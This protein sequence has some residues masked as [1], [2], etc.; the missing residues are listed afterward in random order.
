MPVGFGA[1]EGFLFPGVPDVLQPSQ[2]LDGGQT[3][4]LG[5]ATSQRAQDTAD[6]AD[7]YWAVFPISFVA[8]PEDPRAGVPA[9]GRMPKKKSA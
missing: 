6:E 4:G 3:A 9:L 1:V 8:L 5:V 2:G 7:V